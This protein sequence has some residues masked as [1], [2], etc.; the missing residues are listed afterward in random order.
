[1]TG[2][3]TASVS[4]PPDGARRAGT[5]ARAALETFHCPLCARHIADALLTR[6]VGRRALSYVKKKPARFSPGRP[7]TISDTMLAEVRRR[8]QDGASLCDLAHEFNISEAAA[9]RIIRRVGPYAN[10]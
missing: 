7:R 9:S 3:A 5:Q 6:Y 2:R 1:M 4:N 10:R 8:R